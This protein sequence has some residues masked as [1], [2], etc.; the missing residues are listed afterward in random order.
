MAGALA[1][2]IFEDDQDDLGASFA[3]GPRRRSSHPPTE[4][5]LRWRVHGFRPDRAVE[6]IQRLH[7]DRDNALRRESLFAAA[8]KLVPHYGAIAAGYDQNINRERSALAEGLAD[9]QQLEAYRQMQAE[10]QRRAFPTS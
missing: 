3:A 4:S 8:S 9:L 6:E 1:N 2:M 7:Q 5:D 10:R